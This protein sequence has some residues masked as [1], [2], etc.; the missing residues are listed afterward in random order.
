[1]PLPVT[2][3]KKRH[4]PERAR[5]AGPAG[6]S[7]FSQRTRRSGP[8]EYSLTDQKHHG[9]VTRPKHRPAPGWYRS[10]LR[11]GPRAVKKAALQPDNSRARG[12]RTQSLSELIRGVRPRTPII[13]P[14]AAA[15]RSHFPAEVIEYTQKTSK[16]LPRRPQRIISASLLNFHSQKLGL[17]LIF[18][19]L[20]AKYSDFLF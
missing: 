20:S 9:R 7:F 14:A 16:L 10:D 4:A 18:R 8:D 11:P 6:R 12:E 3:R 17:K 1:M 15:L 19:P 2:G 13:R 5:L